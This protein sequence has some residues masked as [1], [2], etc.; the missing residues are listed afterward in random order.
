MF[1]KKQQPQ[2]SR[3]I[4]ISH[5]IIGRELLLLLDFLAPDKLHFSRSEVL[6]DLPVD[7]HSDRRLIHYRKNNDWKNQSILDV[8]CGNDA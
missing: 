3:L 8:D 6:P 5:S 4:A 1:L 7:L 2:S